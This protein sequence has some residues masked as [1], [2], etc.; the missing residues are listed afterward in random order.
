MGEIDGDETLAFAW[1]SEGEGL[2]GRC[3]SDDRSESEKKVLHRGRSLKRISSIESDR[4]DMA[5]TVVHHVMSEL[6]H[7]EIPGCMASGVITIYFAA[8]AIFVTWLCSLPFEQD[9]RAGC[10]HRAESGARP[11][12]LGRHSRLG[13]FVRGINHGL[14]RRGSSAEPSA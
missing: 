7:S 1:L 2:S 6:A 10:Q 8:P 5:R 13:S 9:L 12:T 11:A 4:S 14:R 3:E